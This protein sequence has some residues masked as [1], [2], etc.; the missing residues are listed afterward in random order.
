MLRDYFRIAWRNLLKNRTSSFI[1]ISGLAVGIAVAILTGLW[2]YDEFTFNTYHDNY[3]RIAKVEIKN[4]GPHGPSMGP[5]LSYPLV[6]EL[7]EKYKEDFQHMVVAS[8]TAGKILSTGDKQLSCDGQY[9]DRDAPD[10]FGLKMVRGTRAGL[11]D[12]RA[13]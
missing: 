1:N 3:E 9:M 6:L 8:W 4:V 2:L 11:S 12:M 13:L 10:L 7:K 5:V